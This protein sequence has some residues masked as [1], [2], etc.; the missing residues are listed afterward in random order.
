[1]ERVQGAGAPPLV[2]LHTFLELSIGKLL[3][4]VN[5]KH[6]KITGETSLLQA[7]PA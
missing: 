6:C 7:G 2:V 4:A 5:G 1:M 3:K